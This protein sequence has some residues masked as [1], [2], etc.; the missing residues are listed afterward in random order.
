MLPLQQVTGRQSRGPCLPGLTGP[1][2]E[3]TP[4]RCV[5]GIQSNGLF[6]NRKATGS[7]LTR[8]RMSH[9]PPGSGRPP[10]LSWEGDGAHLY[11]QVSLTNPGGSGLPPP[12][13]PPGLCREGWDQGLCA[14]AGG[15][16]HWALVP[17]GG[18]T[19][20][21][22]P[23]RH[24]GTQGPPPTAPRAPPWP[25]CGPERG[26]LQAYRQAPPL[27]RQGGQHTFIAVAASRAQAQLLS[28]RSGRPPA[29]GG[30]LGSHSGDWAEPGE[31]KAALCAPW[32]DGT[33]T[34]TGTGG[35]RG[36]RSGGHFARFCLLV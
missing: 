35:W 9:H 17:S 7:D 14:G 16:P 18:R 15:C 21:N 34:G 22:C 32:R 4:W 3:L 20:P 11:G 26:A 12:P 23:S 24:G 29:G 19:S 28:P 2:D 30:P 8:R 6:L 10:W 1:K 13:P 5:Q 25:H 31:R 33:G 27:G 36:T